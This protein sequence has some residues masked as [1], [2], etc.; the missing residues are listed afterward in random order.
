MTKEILIRAGLQVQRFSP[1]SSRRE[2][3][4]YPG[5]HSVGG[6]NNSISYSKGTG[7]DCLPG[8]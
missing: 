4:Q 6:A 8:R 5:R 1:L 7:K 3:W 2:T